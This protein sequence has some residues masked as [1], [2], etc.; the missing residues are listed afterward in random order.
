MQAAE[1]PPPNRPF[2]FIITPGL[3]IDRLEAAA[4]T[5]VRVRQ[6]D[7]VHHQHHERTHLLASGNQ[8]WEHCVPPPLRGGLGAARRTEGM[9]CRGKRG[10]GLGC[11]A[12]GSL[13]WLLYQRWRA[14]HCP[15]DVLQYRAGKGTAFD[16]FK[17]PS[18]PQVA[19]GVGVRRTI[20]RLLHQSYKRAC[21]WP[22]PQVLLSFT[23]AD[24]FMPGPGL[25]AAQ[26]LAL[27]VDGRFCCA[28][29]AVAGVC[30][31][32]PRCEPGLGLGVLD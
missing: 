7:C 28:C 8:Q 9:R 11:V 24:P 2:P 27:G 19:G 32:L 30:S 3:R 14:A 12:V 25:R 26:Q 18:P 21:R 31:L 1:R 15:G 29:G 17:A 16:K 6:Y 5:A 23:R 4:G 22:S 10:C 13:A 20:P